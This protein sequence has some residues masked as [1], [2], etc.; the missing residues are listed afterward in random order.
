MYGSADGAQ[1]SALSPWLTF[2]VSPRFSQALATAIITTALSTH[3]IRSLIG[4]PALL[5]M[6]GLLVAFAA[7]SLNGQRA[8]IEW[9]GILP[10]SLIVLFG[11]IAL[12]VFT[13]QYTWV[14]IGAVS[15]AIVF[16]LLG[17]YLAL[18][19]DLI[20][21]IRAFGSS[22]R[23]ILAA[24]LALE[25]L[26]GILIDT[27]IRFL[28]IAGQL[29]SGGPIQG[30]AGTR[31]YLGFLAGLALITFATEWRTRSVTLPVALTSLGGAVVVL[32]LAR[33]PV[34]FV[35]TAGVLAAG[36][37][38]L[39]LRRVRKSAQ[40]IVQ[41]SLILLMVAGGIV[42]WLFRRGIIDLLNANSEIEFRTGLWQTLRQLIAVHPLE[43]WGW[44]GIWQRHVFPYSSIQG[45]DGR[46]YT[47]GLDVPL[48]TWL[49]V[50]AVGMVILLSSFGLAFLRSWLV[51]SE[52]PIVAYVWPA[53]VLML[54]AITSLAE[55][56]LMFEGG[57]M[58][59]V[60]CA[61][62]AARKRSWRGRY[63]KAPPAR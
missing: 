44:V 2:L 31:N 60:T 6:L 33:S 19:R 53:L 4:W 38:L 42:A 41:G 34:T 43:G 40:P 57:L 52:N 16:G 27:P 55:S 24:S 30:I 37:A 51:A 63:A 29:A 14:T 11:W 8:R 22:L 3:F 23:L 58:L 17:V 13:S 48:D 1:E 62:A 54:L 45:P 61:T 21:I 10:I 18:G 5:A 28:G 46:A 49:Q 20:Q 15:Y 12:S 26:S 32:L 47:S 25:L 36:A 59:F 35:A 56:Y 9:R 7:V 50:G 39:L